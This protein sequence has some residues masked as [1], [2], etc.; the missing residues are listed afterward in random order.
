MPPIAARS[1]DDHHSCH[2]NGCSGHR[3]FASTDPTGRL[4]AVANPEMTFPTTTQADVPLL[5]IPVP[6]L[7]EKWQPV[8]T[9]VAFV[10]PDTA[11]LF[12]AATE[13]PD[14]ISGP[15]DVTVIAALPV[16]IDPTV[17]A[18][19]VAAFVVIGRPEND[20]ADTVP[21]TTKVPFVL[22]AVNA[23]PDTRPCKVTVAPDTF[24]VSTRHADQLSRTLK[25]WLTVL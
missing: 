16:G 25:D 5:L 4:V 3:L 1:C 22:A 24:R 2:S 10:D 18:E 6:A 20:D 17:T 13:Q 12:D 7:P 21:S 9:H 23:Q 11:P 15:V 19:S 8:R 14:M